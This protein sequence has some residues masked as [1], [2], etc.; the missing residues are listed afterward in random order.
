MSYGRVGSLVHLHKR[1]HKLALV[2]RLCRSGQNHVALSLTD[3]VIAMLDGIIV[4]LL[5]VA[6]AVAKTNA[7]PELL[8]L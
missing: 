6:V 2:C 7:H 8:S 5:L 1:D 3:S 4:H